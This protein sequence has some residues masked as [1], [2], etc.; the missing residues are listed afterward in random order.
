MKANGMLDSIKM[1]SALEDAIAHA[2]RDYPEL[3][4]NIA[5][6]GGDVVELLLYDI[7]DYRML[8]SIVARYNKWYPDEITYY[9]LSFI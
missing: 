8:N 2:E 7:K 1:H 6:D 9:S 3:E 5:R 4:I